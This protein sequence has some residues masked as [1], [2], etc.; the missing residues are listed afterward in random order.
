MCDGEHKV[1]T[2][3]N[4]LGYKYKTHVDEDIRE[5]LSKLIEKR[6]LLLLE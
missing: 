6:V 4:S 1:I 2:I 5:L 3:L